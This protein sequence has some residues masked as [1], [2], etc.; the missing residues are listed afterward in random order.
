MF[1]E[2]VQNVWI[3]L[4]FLAALWWIL[5]RY[6]QFYQ[7]EEYD[8]KR[9]LAWWVR[10]RSFEIPVT[11]FAFVFGV[12]SFALS[13]NTSA[14]IN[15][16][17]P[18]VFA[19]AGWSHSYKPSKKKFVFTS[20]ARR[21]IWTAMFV[22]MAGLIFLPMLVLSITQFKT[23][24]IWH[25]FSI[26]LLLQLTPL[27]IVVANC[28]L[29]PVESVIQNKYLKEAK[30]KLHELRPAVIGITGSYGK[31]SMKHLLAQ[32]LQS[33]EPTLYTPG[34]VNTLMGITRIIREQ[35]RSDHRFFVVEMGAYGPGS[36]K[37][38]CGLTP[39]D[40]AIVTV[41]GIAHYER[42][43][44]QE[45]VAAAKSELPQAVAD[46]GVVVLNADCPYC[47]EMKSKTRA[48]VY[49]YGEKKDEYPLDCWLKN[50]EANEAGQRIELEL[51]GKTYALQFPLF[52]KHQ[53]LNVAGAFLLG[54]KL[55]VPPVSAIAAL[56]Q[57]QPVAHRLDVQKDSAG[58]TTID[59]AYNSN[60]DGFRSALDVMKT[61][62]GRR[63]ILVTPGMVE[64]GE[65]SVEEH[66]KIAEYAAKSCDW[67]IIVAGSRIPEFKAALVK[68][69][70]P[71]K[72]II[73]RNT[74]REAR[75]WLQYHLTEGDIVLFENDLPD[76]YESKNAF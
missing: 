39:P 19:A 28:V 11:V 30:A 52:G 45:A 31:T 48:A 53:A 18:A 62:P 74:L 12:A 44:T 26:A 64:L 24:F 16:I 17:S 55:G 67:I 3:D 7:Q 69:G 59:D 4:G 70:F 58:I 22:Q 46:D 65:R 29:K 32:I 10:S 2:F 75:E 35:L 13:A 61:M 60:P 54:V 49:F 6:M 21:I 33:H 36:I 9:F 15:W 47:R 41:V 42:F 8:A 50:I 20:R 71:A 56:Q 23:T 5:L 68:S 14:L 37:Q 63:R 72:S 51:H 34:S 73:E 40:A 43:Q 76:L 1:I 57:M 25:Y 38:L 27:L 66:E